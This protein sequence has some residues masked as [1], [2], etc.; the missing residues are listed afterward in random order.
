MARPK[1]EALTPEEIRAR[2]FTPIPAE[3]KANKEYVTGL[4]QKIATL[5]QDNQILR[6]KMEEINRI[7]TEKLK[8]LSPIELRAKLDTCL[9][10]AGLEPAAE[11]ARM[12]MEKNA[13]DEFLLGP[14][15][16]IKILSELNQY[17]MPKLKAVENTGTVT[18]DHKV[19]IMRF[20]DPIENAKDVTAEIKRFDIN[21]MNRLEDEK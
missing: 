14:G 16:R 2:V 9:A 10:D 1:R 8:N 19:L 13:R 6:A 18:H 20:G 7:K 4:L 11:L 3:E 21:G 5:E 12:V 15:D 17:R